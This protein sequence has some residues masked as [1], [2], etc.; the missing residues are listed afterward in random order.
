[1]MRALDVAAERA[2]PRCDFVIC[3]GAGP[4]AFSAGAEVGDHTPGTRQKN[5]LRV[6][7]CLSPVGCRRLSDYRRRPRALS[8][9]WDGTR[10]VLPILFLPR[11][12]RS[13]PS[14]KSS[15]GCFPPVA[16]V[17]L[18]HL[19]GMRSA[20]TSHSHWRSIGAPEACRLGLVYAGGSRCGAAC[21]SR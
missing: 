15:W 12:P 10:Y 9:R 5:A 11:S 21:R 6:S 8:G 19:I 3:Q 18:P 14:R 20:G 1:M 4:K 17:A 7:R 13:S 2:I 16:M